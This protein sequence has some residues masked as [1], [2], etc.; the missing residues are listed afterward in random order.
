MTELTARLHFDFRRSLCIAALTLLPASSVGCAKVAESK[1]AGTVGA[2]TEAAVVREIDRF[3][4]SVIRSIPVAGLSIV[5]TRGGRTVLSKGYGKADVAAGRDMTA[6]T[7]S[8]IGS[9]TKVFTA[10]AIMK[11][12]EQGKVDLDAP[13]SRYRPEIAAA[14]VTVRQALN[15]T[16]GLPENEGGAVQ[17]WMTQRKPITHEFILG[18]VRDSVS[19][20]PGQTWNYNNTGFHLLGMVIEKASGLPYHEFVRREILDPAGLTATFIEPESIAQIAVT[21]NYYLRDKTFIRDS[22]WDLPGIYAAGGMLSS[23]ADL[24]KL[25]TAIE[26]GRVLSARSVAQMRAPTILPTGARAD[27]GLGIRLGEIAGHPKWGHTGSA[28]S[29]RAAAAYYPRDSLAVVVLMNTEHEDMTT[30]GIEIEGRVAR[31]VLGIRTVRRDDLRLDSARAETYAGTYTDGTVQ[32]RITNRGGI[33]HLSRI[34]SSS[35]AVPLLYQGGEVWADPE[36]AE[37]L[38]VFQKSGDTPTA[39]ARYD[40]GFFVGVRSRTGTAD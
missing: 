27:Y 32:S 19:R 33:L 8:R 9:I 16:S 35:P 31:T 2:D 34:G 39:L 3:A 11:L 36:Y 25:L 18:L 10:I 5:V 17:R 12:V 4:D 22:I 37:Y 28:R 7:A 20:P 6:A 23:A 29:T 1:Q 14:G 15:H 38:F 40:N 13:L 30:G 21:K 24:A 26:N